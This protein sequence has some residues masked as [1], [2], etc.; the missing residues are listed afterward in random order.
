MSDLQP[1]P[2]TAPFDRLLID[3][4]EAARLL[5]VS[6]KTVKRMARANELPGLVKVRRRTLVS[7]EAL[8]KWIGSG[9]PVL[10]PARRAR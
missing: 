10:H 1:P 8:K 6:E 3:L 7:M 5:S 2:A 4:A 9:C